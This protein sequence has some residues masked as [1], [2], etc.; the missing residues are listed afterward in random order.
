MAVQEFRG[1][2]AKTKAPGSSGRGVDSPFLISSAASSPTLSMLEGLI[3][4]SSAIDLTDLTARSEAKDFA[5]TASPCQPT[6]R[7]ACPRDRCRTYSFNIFRSTCLVTLLLVQLLRAVGGSFV[8]KLLRLS[9]VIEHGGHE[10]LEGIE[11]LGVVGEERHVDLE[12]GRDWERRKEASRSNSRKPASP[13][14]IEPLA[15]VPTRLHQRC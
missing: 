3:S 13:N 7:E 10:A 11:F 2:R 4:A 1:Q 6:Q 8:Q 5:C 14:V 15:A 12:C 9:L